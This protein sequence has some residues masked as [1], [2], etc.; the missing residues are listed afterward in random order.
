MAEYS[1]Y[2]PMPT[3]WMRK[4]QTS[5]NNERELYGILQMEHFNMWG[6]PMEYYAT[7]Y[8]T[9]ADNLWSE[10][11]N[12]TITNMWNIMTMYELPHED[13][14]WTK[15]GI[16]GIDQFHIYV[17]KMHFDA[18]TGGNGTYTSAFPQEF[19]PTDS[20][21]PKVGDILKAKYNNYFYQIVN[22]KQEEQMFEQYKHS[23]DLIVKPFTDNRLSLN[24]S[25]S[26]TSISA[27]ANN[28]SD[29]FN[30]KETINTVKTTI[31]YTS[32]ACETTTPSVW[33]SW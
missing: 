30:I 12:R 23:W 31:L 17:S 15:F 29:M 24:N 27:V 7:S 2:D 16:E 10:D 22:V 1:A 3:E 21:L 32:A 11:Q 13:N 18:V 26:A 5:Y 25:T 6:V 4:C 33:G 9:S 20:Y 19:A 14:L 28:Q 8:N